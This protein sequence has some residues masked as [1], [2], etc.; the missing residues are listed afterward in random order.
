[1]NEI[2][3][4]LAQQM[5]KAFDCEDNFESLNV[6][7]IVQGEKVIKSNKEYIIANGRHHEKQLNG[8]YVFQT[9]GYC[10]DDYS[11]FMLFEVGDK[12]YLEIEFEC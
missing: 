8:Y 1:M 12:E 10:E 11:G 6:T 2:L 3:T 4:K 9:S 5:I 7:G